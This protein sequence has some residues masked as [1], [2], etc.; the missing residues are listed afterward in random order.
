MLP[1]S[2]N[3]AVGSM[4]QSCH[5]PFGVEVTQWLLGDLQICQVDQELGIST[6]RSAPSD[7]ALLFLLT[8]LQLCLNSAAAPGD[9]G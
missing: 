7:D 3:A 9:T 1:S 4:N 6:H 5:A 8:L 2:G